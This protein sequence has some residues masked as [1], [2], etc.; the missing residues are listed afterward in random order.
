MSFALFQVVGHWQYVELIWLIFAKLK[1][2]EQNFG[3]FLLTVLV[4]YF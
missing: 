4:E 1:M 2:L 3:Y